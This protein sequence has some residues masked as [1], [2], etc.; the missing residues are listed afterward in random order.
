MTTP[1]GRGL[2]LGFQP[3][4]ERVVITPPQ[5]AFL[6]LPFPRFNQVPDAARALHRR[7][8]T[9]G[10]PGITLHAQLILTLP[11]DRQVGEF[12][13]YRYSHGFR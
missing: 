9:F 13:F 8:S 11:R 6:A 2:Q 7:C 12:V 1:A 10:A 3:V 5:P 4:A